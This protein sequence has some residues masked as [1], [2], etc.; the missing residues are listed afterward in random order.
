MT[1]AVVCQRIIQLAVLVVP[2]PNFTNS[3]ID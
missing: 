1:T 3:R 2:N